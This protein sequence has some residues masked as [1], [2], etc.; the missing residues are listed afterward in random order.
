[1]DKIPKFDAFGLFDI[2]DKVWLGREDKEGPFIFK[3]KDLAEA[4]AMTAAKSLGFSS[5]R[6]RARLFDIS[7]WNRI[8]DIPFVMDPLDALKHLESGGL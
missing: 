1:M 6:I 2:V 3:E 7:T 5:L 4:L 8:E